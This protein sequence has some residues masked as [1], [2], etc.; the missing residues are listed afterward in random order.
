MQTLEFETTMPHPKATINVPVLRLPP[1]SSPV[2]DRCLF[3]QI[4]RYPATAK[5]N[6]KRN[7]D[8]AALDCHATFQ[9]QL[10]MLGRPHA[11][12]HFDDQMAVNRAL[13]ISGAPLS[14]ADLKTPARAAYFRRSYR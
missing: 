8:V 11:W 13:D 3:S 6:R 9:H 2:L 7:Y 1:H 10:I 4:D 12:M 14:L 5:P